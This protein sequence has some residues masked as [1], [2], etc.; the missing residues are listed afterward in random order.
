MTLEEHKE[1]HR[2]LAL[3]GNRSMVYAYC[4]F[5]EKRTLRGTWN[6]EAANKASA[7]RARANKPHLGHKRT[8]ESKLK[9]SEKMKFYYSKPENR[10]KC[11]HKHTEE[12]KKLI[13]AKVREH[14]KTHFVSEETRAKQSIANKLAWN[15]RKAS[16]SALKDD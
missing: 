6:S 12:T 4:L 14:N 15:K 7:E 11:S 16:Q 1:A 3:T 9:Q 8:E 10:A 13:S 2:I 5:G